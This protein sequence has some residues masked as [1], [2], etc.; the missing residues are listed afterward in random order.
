[1]RLR[2][3]QPNGRRVTYCSA[4]QPGDEAERCEY[5]AIGITG[6]SLNSVPLT[7]LHPWHIDKIR[8]RHELLPE[9]T[10]CTT[11][12][13]TQ[14]CPL[15]LEGAGSCGIA[16]GRLK[17]PRI[18]CYKT[19]T[20]GRP[21]RLSRQGLAQAGRRDIGR[22]SLGLPYTGVSWLLAWGTLSEVSLIGGH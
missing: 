22:R 16:G 19:H 6:T 15:L 14:P 21:P 2:N 1:M 17:I 9:S 4:P 11:M 5:Y 10:V 20:G 12:I 3:A 7:L 8:C 18:G 13:E